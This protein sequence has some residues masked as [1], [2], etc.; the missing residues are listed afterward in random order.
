MTLASP[1]M[2]DCTKR[3][4]VVSMSVCS[5]TVCSLLVLDSVS[6]LLKRLFSLKR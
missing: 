5:V 6:V 4:A 2:L 1:E 3:L